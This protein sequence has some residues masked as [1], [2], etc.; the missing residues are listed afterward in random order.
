[1]SALDG[2]IVLAND[3]KALLGEASSDN[4]AL[5]TLSIRRAEG[6]VRRYLK[7]DPVQASRTEYYP[8]SKSRGVQGAHA[9]EATATH[10]VFTNPESTRGN[11]LQLQHIPVRATVAMDLRID[12]NAKAGT[13]AGSFAAATAKVEGTDYWANYDSTDTA[14]SSVC[15]DGIIRA[16]G[17][18]PTEPGSVKVVYTAGYS[19]TELQGQDALVDA[20]PIWDAVIEETIQRAKKALVNKKSATL[21]YLAGPLISERLGDYNY[22]VSDK[23]AMELFGIRAFDLLPESIE[24]LSDGFVNYGYSIFA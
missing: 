16:H 9:L 4:D 13:T 10:A 18:W 24:K 3:I 17:L 8:Q 6:A 1:M 21:G 12:Y 7:Y 5:I 14:G 23:L 11:E 2:R 15:M 19:A 22:K 20:S